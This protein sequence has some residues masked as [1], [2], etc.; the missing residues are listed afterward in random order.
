MYIN[1]EDYKYEELKEEDKKY[2]DAYKKG[3]ENVMQV[4]A[5]NIDDCFD[6]FCS[7][8]YSEEEGKFIEDSEEDVK[9]LSILDKIKYETI[10]D[11]IKKLPDL[12]EAELLDLRVGLIEN[13]MENEIDELE[14]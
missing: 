9:S 14:D 1:E 11:F 4:I 8:Y 2:Y 10:V 6:F 5:S 3:I 7:I 12:M 13:S